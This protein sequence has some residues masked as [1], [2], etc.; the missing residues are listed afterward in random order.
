MQVSDV[1]FNPEESQ[2]K[3]SVCVCGILDPT[4]TKVQIRR[5]GIIGMS[6]GIGEDQ[7]KVGREDGKISMG[8]QCNLQPM[9]QVGGEKRSFG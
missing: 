3:A 5:Y 6:K 8:Q 9:W 4:V 2:Q 7:W 1:L